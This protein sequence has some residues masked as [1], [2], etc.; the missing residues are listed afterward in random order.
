MVSLQPIFRVCVLAL[1]A[2]LVSCSTYLQPDQDTGPVVEQPDTPAAVPSVTL[3][4]PRPVAPPAS[5]AWGPLLTNAEQ[6]TAR[7]DYEQALALLERAH[8]I[9][10]DSAE[11]YLH[12]ARTHRARGDTAQARASA[13]RGILYCNGPAECDALRA[14]TR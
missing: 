5:A 1:V 12:M 13:E 2:S 7:G 9:D 3:P 11:V 6:A 14:Y 10:P 8:R 4:Q